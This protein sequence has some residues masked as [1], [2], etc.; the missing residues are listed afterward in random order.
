MEIQLKQIKIRELIENFRDE[1]EGVYGYSNKLNIRPPYQREFV[2]DDKKQQAVIE[3]ILNGFPLNTM[4]WAKIEDD[5]YEVLDGQQRTL[6]ICKFYNNEFACNLNVLK[7]NT[8]LYYHSLQDDWKQKF[9]DYELHIY[10][11]DGTPTEKLKWFE[12]IN[13]AGEELTKQ[14]LRNAV[15]SGSFTLAAKKIFSKTYCAAYM[16]SKDYVDKTVNRQELLETALDWIVLSQNQY[17][18]IEDYMS[19]H[20]DDKDANEL[21]NY[22][23]SIMDWIKKTFTNHSANR[24]K[25]MK[26]INWGEVYIKFKDKYIDPIELENEISELMK[27]DEIQNKAGIYQYVLS[28]DEKYLHLRQFSDGLKQTAY[29]NQEGKCNICKKYFKLE[30]M[31]ADHIIPWSKGGETTKSNLQMLCKKCNREKSNK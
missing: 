13:T 18:K 1:E 17:K 16:I 25:L 15:Y 27:N 28:K 3:S 22:F 14:E 26:K 8:P 20:K 12:V 19:K 7:N 24:T 9:L 5:K 10:V 29:E 23:E 2:Y 4:Y 11:C 30:E 31:D 21:Q 6:S